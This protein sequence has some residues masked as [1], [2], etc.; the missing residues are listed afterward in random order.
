V[1]IDHNSLKNNSSH[2]RQQVYQPMKGWTCNFCKKVFVMEKAFYK[3]ECKQKKRATEIKT[4]IGQ[5][6]YSYYVVWHRSKIQSAPPIDTF[7]T[8]KYYLPI[9]RFAEMVDTASISHPETYIRIMVNHK[10]DPQ[11][12]C[13]NQSY[14]LYLDW[15]DTIADPAELIMSSMTALER[16]AEKEEVH[17]A[18][19]F[20][21]LGFR[22]VFELLKLRK[23][24]PWFLLNSPN[25]TEFVKGLDAVEISLLFSII[26]KDRWT[27]I[28]TEQAELKK[29]LAG[30]IKAWEI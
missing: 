25:F 9:R 26:N 10:Q 7:A 17:I 1:V 11:M 2:R 23:L 19:I 14:C 5:A 30:Y 28:F 12:W 16:L 20:N 3:H 27:K 15:Y 22:R 8:S 6:A 21:H 13:N 4:R 29:E 24:S 18:G